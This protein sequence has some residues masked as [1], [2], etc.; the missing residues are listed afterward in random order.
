MVQTCASHAGAQVQ[1]LVRELRAYTLHDTAK[2]VFK[3]SK[4]SIHLRKGI[5]SQDSFILKATQQ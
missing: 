2:N 4:L 1:S 5:G 3:R